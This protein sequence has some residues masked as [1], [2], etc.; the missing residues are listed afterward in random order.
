M[1]RVK[2]SAKNDI[3]CSRM[4]VSFICSDLISDQNCYDR[5]ENLVYQVTVGRAH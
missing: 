1:L 2:A 5:M 3:L 4:L